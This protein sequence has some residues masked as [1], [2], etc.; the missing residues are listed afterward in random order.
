MQPDISQQFFDALH[1][2]R[3]ALAQFL[4][5]S[6]Q[7]GAAGAQRGMGARAPLPLLGIFPG[8]GGPVAGG[9]PGQG[10]GNSQAVFNRG[11]YNP[12]TGAAVPSNAAPVRMLYR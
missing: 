4:I 8:R 5:G 12:Q 7:M 2:R 6:G 10:A 9:P 1:R 3:Q 11:L